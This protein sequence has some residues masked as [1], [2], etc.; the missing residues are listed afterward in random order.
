M[1]ETET[2]TRHNIIYDNQSQVEIPATEGLILGKKIYGN[3]PHS[4]GS[5]MIVGK[6]G[7]GKTVFA[8]KSLFEALLRLGYS[9]DEAWEIVLESVRFDIPSVVSYLQE[10]V[11]TGEKKVAL[12]WDDA[13]VFAS[14][15]QY[16]LQ[17]K[18]VNK[19]SG[20]MDT[21]RTAVCNVILT[22]PSSQGLLK[23]LT[24]Y[25][26]F[27]IKINYD[28]ERG[29]TYRIAKAYL[30][31]VLPAGQKRIYKK[32]FDFYSCYLPKAVYDRYQVMRENALKTILS[33]IDTIMRTEEK[34]N[35]RAGHR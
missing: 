17:M 14:G 15:S 8:M 13:R 19:L 12:I 5:Y 25:D 29:G 18:M 24:S 21:I 20:L 35:R 16:F 4:F 3:Y 7:I 6:R 30:W 33:D 27:L 22:C 26:D 23:F 1:S 34:N 11:D 10:A 31:S 28:S 32:W 2:H 9:K